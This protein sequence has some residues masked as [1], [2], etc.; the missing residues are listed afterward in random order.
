M[1]SKFGLFLLLASCSSTS[2]TTDAE[3]KRCFL[4]D[5]NAAA[6]IEP[7]FRAVDGTIQP[8]TELGRVPLI[9]PPQGGKIVVVGAQAKNMDGCPVQ[10]ATS[11]RDTCTGAVI[12]LE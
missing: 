7:I 4:G 5:M 10:I 2:E 6:A 8:I 12:A 9:L 3:V 1:R 11:L